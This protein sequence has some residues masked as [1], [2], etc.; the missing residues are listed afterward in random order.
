MARTLIFGGTFDPVHIGHLRAAIE[1]VETLGFDRA[2]WI[3]SYRPRHKTDQQLL[4]FDL[5]VALLRAAIDGHALFHVN[6]I[7]RSLPVPSL[8][9]QTLEAL[10]RSDSDIERHFLLG[11]REFLRLPKWVRGCDVVALAHIVIACRTEFDAE[12]FAASVAEAWPASRRIDPVPGALMAFELVPGRRAVLLPLPRIEV[13]S[14][15]V[16]SRWLEGRS[17]AY[18]VPDKAIEVLQAHRAEV[19]KLWSGRS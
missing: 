5:R 7:E 13:S 4:P 6:E 9:I 14:S 1:V 16:R 3:P 18:L 11:D 17:L 10:A 15:L 19:T 8:T 12:T 2:E